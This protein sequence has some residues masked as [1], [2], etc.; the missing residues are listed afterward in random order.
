MGLKLR[1]LYQL[2]IQIV[3]RI[4]VLCFL[5][6]LAFQSLSALVAHAEDALPGNLI[7]GQKLSIS[8]TVSSR[9]S[10]FPLAQLNDKI[11]SDASPYNGF[12]S[13]AF[14]GTISINL[15]KDYMLNGFML[16]NDI[17]VQSEGIAEFSLI[18][19]NA[20]GVKIGNSSLFTAPVGQ[21]TPGTYTFNPIEGVRRVDLVIS[22]THGYWGIEIREI[23]LLNA[24]PENYIGGPAI[25][26]TST[27]SP[28]SSRFPLSQLVDQVTSDASPFNGFAAS[29]FAGTISLNLDKDYTLTALMLWNDINV[30]S[31]GISNF[32]L[33]FFDRYGNLI[34]KTNQFTPAIRLITPST[35][36]FSPIA[37]VRRVDLVINSSYGAYG[38]EIRELGFIIQPDWAKAGDKASGKQQFATLC[39][40]CHGAEGKSTSNPINL[41]NLKS[42]DA[43]I[44]LAKYIFENMPKG[45]P[46]ACTNSN[47]DNCA[48]NVAAYLQEVNRITKGAAIWQIQCKGCHGTFDYGISNVV[49]KLMPLR[50]TIFIT[51]LLPVA[52]TLH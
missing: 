4:K 16:W 20:A 40:S 1:D 41:D 6:W 17:N 43:K 9:D 35:F 19:Y 25:N 11:T 34:G 26:P 18:F 37:N 39:A 36:T 46:A 2:N 48:A 14:T 27:V 28:R 3:S 13:D 21:S 51:I 49:E 15:D 8:S 22:K 52:H 33:E 30:Q 47:N 45:N 29:A 42:A 7:W 24:L 50:S 44:N 10:R 38:I 12:A 5:L 32:S 31:E 23:A